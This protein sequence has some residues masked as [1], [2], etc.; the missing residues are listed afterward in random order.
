MRGKAAFE[1]AFVTLQ[2]ALVTILC[3]AAILCTGGVT[4]HA[5]QS[6]PAPAQDFSTAYA[7]AHE[8]CRALWSDH[9][10]DP[11][12]GKLPLGVGKPT[13]SML[14]NR[15]RLPAKDKKLADLA[16][17]TL[18]K[19]RALLA[20][21]LALLPEQ[22][23]LLAQS[24]DQE[25]DAAIAQ[26]YVGKITFGEYNIRMNQ[27]SAEQDKALY[28]DARAEMPSGP[29]KIVGTNHGPVPLPTP[30]PAQ[31]ASAGPRAQVPLQRRV[32]LVIG[33]S[34]YANLPGLANPANDARAMADG[35]RD[36]GFA[37]T[38]VLDASEQDLRRGVRT[39]AHDSDEAELAVVFYA[40]HGAQINGE[41]FL[42]PVDIDV[43][44]TET[45]I[46]LSGLK[47]DDLVNAIRSD[48]KIVFLDACRDNPALF[49][50][51]VKGRGAVPAGLAP[52][53]ASN[54]AGMKPG[55]G[56]FIAYATDAGSVAADGDGEH[57]P[58]TQA[59]LRNLKQPISIDNMFSRVTHEVL[60]VTKN[61]QRP[62]K[63]ASLENIVCL[64]GHCSDAAPAAITDIGQEAKRSETEELQIALQTDSPD[65]LETYLQK[66]PD[67]SERERIV[68]AISSLKR[69]ESDAWTLFG[70]SG[71]QNQFPHYMR[72]SSIHQFGDRVSYQY[73][74]LLDDTARS[75]VTPN[76]PEGSVGE[77]TMVY[78]CKQAIFA[79]AERVVIGPS[80]E[81]LFHFK[82]ADPEFLNMSTA[83]APAPGSV[84]STARNILC[85]EELR[86]PL[87]EK[88]RLAVMN[89]PYMASA[90]SGDGEIYYELLQN[91][92][93]S[94]D[95]R[96]A[97]LLMRFAKDR[98]L[99][100][101]VVAGVSVPGL[102]NYRTTVLH[103]QI[104][105]AEG[106]VA[107][108]KKEDYDASNNLVFLMVFDRSSGIE[109][110]DI[111]KNS[112]LATLQ[113]IA[114]GS[115]EAQK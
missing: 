54:L 105:C 108:E 114:C 32:A 110:V 84:A 70:V 88:R 98:P 68:A 89:F 42:L 102:L 92:G 12:R 43:P 75:L 47:V 67:S 4:L 58:F 55:G 85:H 15:D 24:F 6:S 90:P 111:S 79:P 11:L 21:S 64:T 61:L 106:K 30:R 35:L 17:K 96:D 71:N 25:Q 94:P 76:V 31:V 80:G 26:L 69:K 8:Q 112:P 59:L 22:T 56:V 72:I 91:R 103:E 3:A 20:P 51:L 115:Q 73:K 87:L 34:K 41:N 27:I 9:V 95:E 97:L 28:G 81:R 62:Y 39:F 66:Y 104:K 10:F 16:I 38:L 18:E 33:N 93:I 13:F 53:N 109:W 65:A 19:C 107:L 7:S 14:T 1:F 37:V 29:Q 5:Q 100:D 99:A 52:A 78:D 23:R 86:T 46:G 40:G 101:E 50:N 77:Y 2:F 57:S 74:S 48:T 82:W 60:L 36:M 49:K 44:R 63:Y 83:V 113:I 45:D